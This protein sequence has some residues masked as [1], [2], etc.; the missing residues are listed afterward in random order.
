MADS[1]L[2]REFLRTVLSL[3]AKAEVDRLLLVADVPLSAEDLRGRALQKKLGYAV[4][5][6]RL[7]MDIT[8]A[9]ARGG[10]AELAAPNQRRGGARGA[11]GRRPGPHL[12][13]GDEDFG[14]VGGALG[15]RGGGGGVGGRAHLAGWSLRRWQGRRA[16]AGAGRAPR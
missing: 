2:D 10:G 15:H 4:T 11:G 1:K 5:E 13:R 6:E 7:A 8:R 16:A 9:R 12:G 14:G 3:A